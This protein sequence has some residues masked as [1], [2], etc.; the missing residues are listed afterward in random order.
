[1]RGLQYFNL[2][3]VLALAVLCV[4]QWHINRALNLQINT[5]EKDRIAQRARL[6]EQ[7]AQL[8]GQLADLDSF[9]EHVK[10]ASQSI[11]SAESNLVVVRQEAAQLAAERDQLK[12]SVTNWSNAVAERDDRLAKLSGQVQSLASE[13]NEAIVKFNRVAEQ[14]NQVVNDLN[15]RTRE[16]NALVEKYNALAKAAGRSSN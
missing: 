5:L 16:Y 8:K 1:M 11:R 6:D 4:V 2:A 13:R 9:R 10:Q 7:D 14:Q 3:G 12:E 15:E